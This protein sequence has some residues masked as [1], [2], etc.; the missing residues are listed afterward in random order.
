MQSGLVSCRIVYD[1]SRSI[2]IRSITPCS[3]QQQQQLHPRS[4][5]VHTSPL[6]RSQ[7]LV[8]FFSGPTYLAIVA[9]VGRPGL[10]RASRP[11]SATTPRQLRGSARRRKTQPIAAALRR[12]YRK[13]KRLQTLTDHTRLVCAVAAV[14]WGREVAGWGIRGAGASEVTYGSVIQRRAVALRRGR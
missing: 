12:E 4:I 13:I 1:G 2:A 3:M 11:T 10:T 8:H 7:S 14:R 6:S 5:T 9:S